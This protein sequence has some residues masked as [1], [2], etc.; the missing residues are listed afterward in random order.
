MALQ[1]SNQSVYVPE[2]NSSLYENNMVYKKEYTQSDCK[3][4]T[5]NINLAPNTFYNYTRYNLRN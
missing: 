2:L 5:L 3:T 1:K 4:N